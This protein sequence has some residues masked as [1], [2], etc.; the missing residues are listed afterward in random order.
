MYLTACSAYHAFSASRY[1][2]S[3]SDQ[4]SDDQLGIPDFN[5]DRRRPPSPCPSF[6]SLSSVNTHNSSPSPLHN[7]PFMSLSSRNMYSPSPFPL[8]N[9]PFPPFSRD[10]SYGIVI[11]SVKKKWFEAVMKDD[12][13][14]L[15]HILS[16]YIFDADE[17]SQ[18]GNTAFLMAC[19]LQN[20]NIASYLLRIGVNRFMRNNEGWTAFHLSCMHGHKALA[21]W[22]LTLGLSK[23]ALDY[24]GNNALDLVS[25]YGYH[26]KQEMY[27]YLLSIGLQTKAIRQ[28]SQPQSLNPS[29]TNLF[30]SVGSTTK[31]PASY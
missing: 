29:H 21:A 5:F 3:T 24:Q 9:L 20:K 6:M 16:N 17:V 23:D 10:L 13:P 1:T 26:A 12:L 15:Q 8:N 25:L 18:E 28:I 4:K 30:S 11:D 7:P 27:A 22:L 19:E 2:S 14:A 31:Q